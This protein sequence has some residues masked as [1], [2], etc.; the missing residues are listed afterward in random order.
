MTSRAQAR[1]RDA[2]PPRPS[3]YP[4]VRAAVFECRVPPRQLLGAFGAARRQASGLA[5][6]ERERRR[7]RQQRRGGPRATRPTLSQTWWCAR[8]T[9]PAARAM[10][11]VAPWTRFYSNSCCLCC[12]VRTGT[13][14]LGVWYLVS[15]ATRRDAPARAGRGRR[16]GSTR[17]PGPRPAPSPR[18]ARPQVGRPRGWVTPALIRLKLYY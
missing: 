4:P 10:K 1:S 7:S 8:F 11:M 12:H 2:G 17:A 5:G 6:L 3:L 9:A 13:I 14:L 18:F 15:A 16:G